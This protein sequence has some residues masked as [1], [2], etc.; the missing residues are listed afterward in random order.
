MFIICKGHLSQGSGYQQV[1]GN[2]SCKSAWW[3]GYIYI[4]IYVEGHVSAHQYMLKGVKYTSIGT[5][6]LSPF[7]SL[8]ARVCVLG[9]VRERVEEG[10][11]LAR[12]KDLR[13]GRLVPSANAERAY[14]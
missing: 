14:A 1:S 7:Q 4:Y 5:L 8:C 12:F 3:E 11:A 10:E 9:H 6:K 13:G 2:W